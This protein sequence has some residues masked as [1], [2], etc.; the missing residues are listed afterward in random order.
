MNTKSN[1]EIIIYQTQDGKTKI[2]VTVDNDTVWL[3]Q[4][5][6]AEL[7]QTTK[8]NISLHIKN[9]F[10]EGELIELS[11]VKEYLTVQKEG[12]RSIERNIVYYNLNMI[13]ALGYRVKSQRATHF[14]IW[15]TQ[16]LKEYMVKGFALNDDMLKKAGGG[17][18]WKELLEHIRDIRSSERVFYRQILDIYATSIDYNP[19]S[20]ES[21]QFFKVVQNKMHFAA[22]GHTVSEIVYLRSDSAKV[23]MGMTS[24]ASDKP[25]KSDITIAKN[26]LTQ[27]ELKILNSIVSAYLEFAE[28][29]ALRKKPMYMKDW[30]TKLDDFIKMSGNELLKNSGKISS[31]KAENKAI[32]E[33]AKYKEKTKDE[34]STV[35][36]DFIRSIKDTQKKLEKKDR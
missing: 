11:T 10:L 1:G 16:V 23:F 31:I 7:F 3:S 2:D 8:Q 26:Y 9:I 27:D 5:D 32:K 30:I 24:F 6:M 4:N 22:H 17:G 34:L 19:N 25:L 21:K 35:E 28:L 20:K 18:Y 33:Y 29:Q 14:R 13:I 15:A 12:K 36:K